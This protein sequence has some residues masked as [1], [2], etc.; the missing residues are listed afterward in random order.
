[1]SS[2]LS[3]N[4]DVVF[5]LNQNKSLHYGKLNSNTLLKA[6]ATPPATHFYQQK[7]AFMSPTCTNR[8]SGYIINVITTGL[9][10][11]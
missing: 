8:I 2:M 5:L 7:T 3:V 1:M 11:L 4:T 6:W 9:N 10:L